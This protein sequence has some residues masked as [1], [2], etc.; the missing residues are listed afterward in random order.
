MEKSSAFSKI[1]QIF[2]LTKYDD[3]LN[4]Q[5]SKM[6][7]PRGQDVDNFPRRWLRPRLCK[8]F[9]GLTTCTAA[10]RPVFEIIR[11]FEYI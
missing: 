9:Y 4:S 3:L 2:L 7:K 8:K 10:R 6:K 1:N 5:R 11:C